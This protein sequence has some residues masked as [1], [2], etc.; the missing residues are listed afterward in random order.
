MW[1]RIT[2]KEVLMPPHQEGSA[3]DPASSTEPR[4]MQFGDLEC[5]KCR[6]ELTGLRETRCPECGEPFD[7]D[8]HRSRAVKLVAVYCVRVD[9][10]QQIVEL[11]RNAGLHPRA[12]D[13]PRYQHPRAPLPSAPIYVPKSEASH[14]RRVLAHWERE[15]NERLG[16]I[17]CSFR[18]Q[19]AVA[20]VIALPCGAAT[21]WFMEGEVDP[22]SILLYSFVWF[23]V[24]AILWMSVSLTASWWRESR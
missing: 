8:P 17:A 21:S 10:Q 12:D 2:H 14:A 5:P 6:Y 7:G 24:G 13:L 23:V 9:H 15:T 4:T 20:L 18:R 22:T 11:L 16:R 1:T 19:I 3:S